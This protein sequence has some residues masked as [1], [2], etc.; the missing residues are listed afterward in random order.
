[1]G[2]YE[3][4]LAAIIAKLAEGY[5]GDLCFANIDTEAIDQAVAIL[6]GVYAEGITFGTNCGKDVG[7]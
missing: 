3:Q 6:K 1:M 5:D 4:E 7:A 2:Y